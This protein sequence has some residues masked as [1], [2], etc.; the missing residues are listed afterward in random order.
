MKRKIIT[1]SLAI[2][3]CFGLSAQDMVSKKGV[4]ILPESGDI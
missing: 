4:S 2:G 1:C 3:L